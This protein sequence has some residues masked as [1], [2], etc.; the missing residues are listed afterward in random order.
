MRV[1]AAACVFVYTHRYAGLRHRDAV[2]VHSCLHTLVERG[3]ETIRL[4]GT[5]TPVPLRAAAQT[6]DKTKITGAVSIR[7]INKPQR[8][9]FYLK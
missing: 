3:G 5:F 8:Y 4:V 9:R 2:R 6:G 1:Y 7:N